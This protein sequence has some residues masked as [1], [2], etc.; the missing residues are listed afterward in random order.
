M[1]I[2]VV[3]PARL[4]STR[5]PNKVLKDINGKSMIQRVW[6]SIKSVALIDEVII[7][8][9]HPDIEQKATA[10]GA[11]VIMTREDH[12]C[13]TDRIIEASKKLTN[14]D[15]LINVQADEVLIS[16]A[17]LEPIINYIKA[18]KPSIITPHFKNHSLKDF[19]NPNKVK[20]VITKESKVVYFSRASIP[21]TRDA[22]EG[23]TG[24][25]NQHAGIYAFSAEMLQ[26]IE[27]LEPTPLE[28]QEKLEQLRWLEHNIDIHTVEIPND[29]I[30]VDT[31]EDLEKVRTLF[32]S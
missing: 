16:K 31:L 28:K 6:E 19:Q 2:I 30:G 22:A 4:A 8:A 13:G 10:F 25:F 18:H 29:L 1:R 11:K 26:K 15:Y 5:L 3:I 20:L 21:F 17:H 14:F 7:A 12:I 24:L 32:K 27:A 9:D 23:F